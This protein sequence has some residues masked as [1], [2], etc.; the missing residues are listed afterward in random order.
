MSIRHHLAITA[1][2]N[3]E[4]DIVAL[5][6]YMQAS[7]NECAF[8]NVTPRYDPAI[9]LLASQLAMVTNTDHPE[10]MKYREHFDACLEEI[11]NDLTAIQTPT[12]IN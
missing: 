7:L 6:S 11:T 5:V 8:A 3:Q 2:R 9:L 4:Q 12:N 1:I 10:K